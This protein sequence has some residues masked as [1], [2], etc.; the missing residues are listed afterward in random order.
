MRYL[1]RLCLAARRALVL[2]LVLGATLW[3]TL[4]LFHA[5]P[6][7]VP[8]GLLG[9]AFG[10]SGLITALAVFRWHHAVPAL[11][12]F[13]M[14]M[15][16][17]LGWWNGIEPSNERDWQ[18]D[19]ARLASVEMRGDIVTVRNVRNFD[20][21]SEMD[22]TPAYEDRS[23]D[24]GK[25][26][27]VDLF[28]V[29]WMGPAIA[30]TIVSFGFEGEQYLAISI[31]TRKEKGEAY[32]TLKGFFRQYEL[33]YVVADERDVIR[34]RTNYRRDPPEEVHLYRL[35]GPPENGRRLFVQYAERINA[36]NRQAEFYNTLTDNCTTA[37]WMNSRI[38]PGHVPL[39]WKIL[40]S[41][42]LPDYL[43]EQG[44]LAPST[45]FSELQRRGQVDARAREADQ[46][47]DFSRRIRAGIPGM[48]PAALP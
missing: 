33:Y 27:S 23:Y 20:Y 19:V 38:N 17:V 3:G 24:L 43:H 14:L 30:H 18:V 6:A 42:Y 48:Q 32:S 29:Y 11:L 46:A 37:I 13:T 44:L 25:L 26:Q 35:H 21:R 8:S 12:G 2:P 1:S 16:L 4:A 7:G 40:A 41:G 15:A 31:E 45:P 10:L 34:L 5:G 9:G 36:L 28:S 39:S 22:Y 47:S